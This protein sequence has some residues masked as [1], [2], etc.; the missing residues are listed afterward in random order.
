MKNKRLKLAW[1]RLL[2]PYRMQLAYPDIYVALLGNLEI[3]T[4]P[5]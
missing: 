1:L 2:Y 3:D 4:K 5:D